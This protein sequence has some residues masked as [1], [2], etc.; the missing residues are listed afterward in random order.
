MNCSLHVYICMYPAHS[1][2]SI[3]ISGYQYDTD[4]IVELCDREKNKILLISKTTFASSI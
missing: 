2:C 4:P 3:N 1:N